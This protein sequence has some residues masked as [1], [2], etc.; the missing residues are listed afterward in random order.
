MR[1]AKALGAV[2]AARRALRSTGLAA[3]PCSSTRRAARQACAASQRL[4]SG[5]EV[6]EGVQHGP[7]QGRV[8][9][10]HDGGQPGGAL[11]I[12]AMRHQLASA[13]LLR[14]QPRL[15]LDHRCGGDQVQLGEAVERVEVVDPFPFD[16]EDRARSTLGAQARHTLGEIVEHQAG[17]MPQPKNWPTRSYSTIA[18]APAGR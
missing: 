3:L 8:E 15:P 16:A 17:M 10:R 2:Q 7:V 12:M 13:D 11:S 14:G 6:P 18:V 9:A 1:L 5:L 4:D